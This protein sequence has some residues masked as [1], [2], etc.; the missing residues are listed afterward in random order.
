MAELPL[1]TYELDNI[2]T[3]IAYDLYESWAVSGRFEE[4]QAAE[5]AELAA[6]DTV[7]VINL[8]MEKFNEFMSAKQR[9]IL[10]KTN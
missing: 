5:Y 4:D 3:Q 2:V 7:F 6:N 10:T 1:A 8:F 9:E